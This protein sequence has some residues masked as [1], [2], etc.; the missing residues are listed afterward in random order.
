ML[1]YSHAQD[2]IAATLTQNIENRVRK[3][4][5]PSNAAQC[6]MC[7]GGMGPRLWIPSDT[8]KVD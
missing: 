7:Q 6:A 1:E 3:L 4:P 8:V 5:K 2:F